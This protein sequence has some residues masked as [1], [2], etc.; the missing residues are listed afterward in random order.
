MVKEN[1]VSEKQRYKRIKVVLGDNGKSGELSLSGLEQYL[2]VR[3]DM[4]KEFLD[5]VANRLSEKKPVPSDKG[6]VL[7]RVSDALSIFYEYYPTSYMKE[8][9]EHVRDD[10]RRRKSVFNGLII[11]KKRGR[12][13]SCFVI[14]EDQEEFNFLFLREWLSTHIRDEKEIKRDFKDDPEEAKDMFVTMY[15]VIFDIKKKYGCWSL[16]RKYLG[17]VVES[18]NEKYSKLFSIIID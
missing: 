4:K 10:C 16:P 6:P 9:V 8:W 14:E 13:Y 3:E 15:K 7:V 2:Y 12:G 5:V 11:K 17:D 18:F 1:S